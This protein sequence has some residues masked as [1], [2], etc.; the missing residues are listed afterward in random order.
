MAVLS[1]GSEQNEIEPVHNEE[2]ER[3]RATFEQA[4]VGM[5]HV[6][7]DGKWLLVNQRLCDILGYTREEL[8]ARTYQSITHPDDMQ[9]DEDSLL[10]F[11][12]DKITTYWVEKRYI[13]K[14]QEV[15]WVTLTV[16][17]ARDAMGAPAYFI[18]VIED[19]TERKEME[20]ALWESEARHAAIL[21]TSL[22]AIITMD[23]HGRVVEWN[24][25]AERTFGYS[26]TEAIGKQV[27]KLII[28]RKLRQRHRN[29]LRRYLSTGS[30][31]LLGNRTEMTAL[32]AGGSEFPVELSINRIKTGSAPLFAAYARDI[33]TQRQAQEQLRIQFERLSALRAID[34]VILSSLNLPATL[35]LILDQVTTFLGVHAA[36]LFVL[37]R[38]KLTLEF[39]M[40]RGFSMTGPVPTNI[41][42]REGPVGRAALERRLLT[43]DGLSEEEDYRNERL[44]GGLFRDYYA[45]PL[46]AK[47]ELR[48][49]LEV[50]HRE[51]LASDREWIEFLE[52]LAGHTALA[53]DNARMF[54]DVQQ[55]N[56]E[57][58]LSYDATI[59]GWSHA[60]DLRDKETEGHSERVTDLTLR[61]A[62]A[63]GIDA[64]QQT[65]MRRGA[66]L[67]DIGKMGVPDPILHKPGALTEEERF[68][69]Q[70]HPEYAY[71]LLYPIAF[72]RP[73][74]EI[75]LCHHEKWDGTGYPHGLLG[76]Q[77][78]ISA[79]I[80]AVVDVW[81]ALC[82]DRPYRPAWPPARVLEHIRFLSGSHFDPAV[83]E[84]FV[85]LMAIPP[86][87]PD[88]STFPR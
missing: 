88:S 35:G 18:S 3:F 84:A 43:I 31:A 77:I 78:P 41:P 79:R 1:N 15:V 85:K 53:I 11:L 87:G 42:L 19:I 27:E 39:I 82:S 16:S 83:V 62:Q 64:V 40:G 81:D 12:N 68:L 63:M 66:L 20:Q 59:Q 47:G 38:N 74:L 80:F 57:L 76:K 70:R 56:L 32:H 67:H 55:A 45:I 69:M 23:E 28:P 61:L 26:Q 46:I 58:T 36:A 86:A 30:S 52:T 54:D 34:L 33:T 14:N 48:G 21:K 7:L 25:A 6:G 24:P 22:D 75:P 49:L 2:E 13:H 9:Q 37:D 65:H 72:L 71:N 50:Y 29:G 17:L 44:A 60:L 5:A 4:A 51:S 10:R 73:A 8:L